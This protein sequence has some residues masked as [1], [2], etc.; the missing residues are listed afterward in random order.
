MRRNIPVSGL[1]LTLSL[2]LLSSTQPLFAQSNEFNF[3]STRRSSVNADNQTSL[4]LHNN[5]FGIGQTP[6][7]SSHDRADQILSQYKRPLDESN[8]HASMPITSVTEQHL[9]LESA[10]SVAANQA[11]AVSGNS[12]VQQQNHATNYDAYGLGYDSCGSDLGF[13]RQPC[14]LFPRGCRGWQFSGWLQTGYHTGS[15]GLLNDRPD[16]FNLHQGWFTIDRQALTGGGWDWGFR[17]DTVYGTDAYFLQSLGNNPGNWDFQNGLDHGEYAWAIPQLYGEV[18]YNNFILRG[19]H[20]LANFN[21]ESFQSPRNFFYSRSYASVLAAPITMTGVVASY[22]DGCNIWSA[23]YITG[24]DTG[25]DQ[26]GN[27]GAFYGRYERRLSNQSSLS[28]TTSLGDFGRRGDGYAH[29]IAYNRNFGCRWNYVCETTYLQSEL[30]AGGNN[31]NVGITQY[32]T[33]RWSN[34]LDAGQRLEW[35]KSDINVLGSQSTYAYT[36]G[37]N[38]RVISNINIR[39]EVRYNWGSSFNSAE[40]STAIFGVDAVLQF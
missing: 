38:Y 28:Y 12:Q 15:D 19:G 14:R 17:I 8:Q 27:G 32:L 3:S 7:H 2:M 1:S 25:F 5:G 31:D 39:P 23:G 24:W 11:D 29:S 40:T 9:A 6:A 13:D 22:D 16:E 33:Y 20:F 35:W 10:I 37:L 30:P 4:K 18:Q 36:A 34:K 26:F 21:Y